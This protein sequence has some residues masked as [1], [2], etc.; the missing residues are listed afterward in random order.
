MWDSIYMAE[1]DNL[2]G[3]N[4]NFDTIKTLLNSIRAQG[5]LN[6]SDVDKLLTGIN[7]KLEKINTEE[8]IDLIKI[9][10][11]ELKQNLDERHSILV[12]KFGAIE[13]L[14]S[15]LLKNSSE[16]LKSSEVKELF[17]IVATNLSVFSREVVSQKESL[18][19]I[20]LR[21][22]AL[23]SDDSQKK[24]IIK[25][26]ALLK[27]DLE[28]LNNG[29]DSIVLSLNDNFKTIVKTISTIDKTEYLDKFSDS[30]SNIEMSSK[31]VLSALQVLDKKT[32]KVDSVL[33]NL[34]RK[35]DLSETN[36][37]IFE[38]TAQSH[39]LSASVTDLAD[40]YVRFDN[41]AD[42]I[43]ASVGI[44]AGLKSFL[45]EADD[46]STNTLL[47]ELRGIEHSIDK[48]SSDTKFEDFK[49]DLQ[50]I[51]NKIFE[52]TDILNKKFIDSQADIKSL[53]NKMSTIDIKTE[54]QIIAEK[55]ETT[56]IAIKDNISES[57]QKVLNLSE[58]NISRVLNEI[59]SSA[60]SL[61]S[62]LT[63]TQSSLAV[64]CEKNFGSVYENI[65]DLKTVLAQIDENSI[66]ANNAI[67]SSITDRLTSFENELSQSLEAQERTVNHSAAQLIEQVENIK[68]LSGVLDYKIDSSVVE[69]NSVKSGLDNLKS[70][71]DDVLALNFVN[72][73]KDLRIDLYASKQEL[74]NS[75]ETTS[76]DMADKLTEDL[77]GKY[78]LLISKLDSVE[79]EIKH[80]QNESLYSLKNVLENISSSIVD[81]LSYVSENNKQDLSSF[82]SKIA[83]ISSSIKETNL[84]YVESV[85][86]IV[87]VIRIQV[88]NNLKNIEAD[89]VGNFED[90]KKSISENTDELKQEIK[91]SYAKLLE[92][93]DSYNEI[94]DILNLYDASS[95]TKFDSI[96][97]TTNSIKTEFDAK[98]N[99]LK[100]NLLDKVTEF[101]QEYT[102]DN[103]DR[104]SDIKFAVENM[105][106][107]TT[108]DITDA[109]DK[110]KE[111]LKSL[112]ETVDSDMTRQMSIIESNFESLISQMNIV[113]EK[114]EMTLTEKINSEFS[115]LSNDVMTSV[116]EKLNLYKEK[117]DT[118]FEELSTKA[119][120]Q[121]EYLQ[122]RIV[123]L[124]STM[125]SVWEEQS[126]ENIKQIEEMANQFRAV[127]DENIKLT[128][129]DY[130]ALKNKLNDFAKNIESNNEKLSELLS[131]NIEN[132][133]QKLESIIGSEFAKVTGNQEKF[134]ASNEQNFNIIKDS[135]S[136]TQININ[137]KLGALKSAFYEASTNDMASISSHVNA[138]LEQI[139]ASRN[140]VIA[141]KEVLADLFAK[142]VKLLTENIEKETDA[143]IA[144]LVEQ[145]DL[146]KKSQADDIINLTTKIEDIVSG[147]IFNNIEDLKSYLDV[148]TD[149]T[150]FINRIDN[151]KIE[152]ANGISDLLER[153]NKLL[154][155]GVFTSSIKDFKLANEVLINSSIDRLNDKIEQFI[156]DNST[157][158]AG[159]IE[160]KSIN[161]EDKLSL[162]DK[163]FVETLVEKYE[164]I[165]LISNNC[166]K[167]LSDIQNEINNIFTKFESTKSDI[168]SRID[169]LI[170][171]INTANESTSNDVKE[172]LIAFNDLKSHLS[173]KSFDEAFQTSI[174]NQITGLE[175]LISEQ[176]G[177]I[178]DINDLCVANLPDISDLKGLIKDSVL[179]LVDDFSKKIDDQDIEGLLDEALKKF[180]SDIITQ[181]LNVFNQISFVAE[182]EEI[183]DFIQEKHEDLITILSHIV[184][185]TEG[186]SI[187]ENKIDTLKD[188]IKSINEKIMAIM[189]SDGDIDYVY[190]L[191]DIE[192][193]IA[194]LRLALN[195]IKQ[196]DN[197]KDLAELVSSTN[198][199]YALVESVKSELPTKQ[200]FETIAENIE[201]ISSR[202]NKLILNSDESYKTL[203]E[204][205]QEF[206]LVIDDLDERTRNFSKDS[207]IDKIDLK[208]NSINNLIQKGEK[209]NQVFNQVFEYLAE[210][211]DNASVQINTISDRVNSLDDIEQIKNILTELKEGATDNSESLEL[212]NAL[213]VVFNKQ[214]KKITSLEKKL[215]KIIVETTINSQNN[216]INL[217][218]MEDTLNKFLVA[219]DDKMSAQQDK[220]ASLETKLENVFKILD[221]KDTVQ[222]TKKVGGM[223]RQIAK[224]NKSIEKI[225]SH[226]VEK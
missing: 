191:Q 74:V 60:D 121:S 7:T 137:E 132:L 57:T 152:V 224:L 195:E 24:D 33:E 119:I 211:V 100:T 20:S 99:I 4:E 185:T 215:D 149:N 8:D 50:T 92:I 93:I 161:I 140:N 169:L 71:V 40:K 94:K 87:D 202:T 26:I 82:D 127:I 67:F 171:I 43:D 62:R 210:W 76:S 135:L 107:K 10:L 200:D 203:Q 128:A 28:R 139:D 193:D 160:Q 115:S 204:N 59:S 41:L 187:V 19:D 125:K 122:D 51:V 12:S 16:M 25:N 196:N 34:A 52:G 197:G 90:V 95:K 168:N 22:D 73:V 157:T 48:I 209:T 154:E 11:S 183:I 117:I 116:A 150:D 166:D 188:D 184:T 84:N 130:V 97:S 75:Y 18:T 218:P 31:T 83:E 199:V 155:T 37:K 190:S 120:S 23:R 174:N 159:V 213:E 5:I 81:V 21:L 162:F 114:T 181:F 98:L 178:E 126:E 141:C 68:N 173:S 80:A 36:R 206:K 53:L 46:K 96:I 134:N 39:E 225:A 88:E 103:A 2:A 113:S 49:N 129:V 217:E 177:Y 124:N 27:P 70:A 147:Q 47:E 221:E 89:S 156:S 6:T 133:N 226:V 105:Y 77:Y 55:F 1:M 65:T 192:A 158:I 56:A 35:E 29:F 198:Q 170:D 131:E 186:I 220:I 108:Q 72:V 212:V 30:L 138:I 142:D 15:N 180:K 3:I 111:I 223:D 102:C 63:E 44:I 112:D 78:E 148:K 214:A 17:D 143:I 207:G 205:L 86:D 64:L 61:S 69:L 79:E 106:S 153:Q 58:A 146:I 110:Q 54:Y 144:E 172:I 167:S 38:L 145:F 85:R 104:M 9:F 45:E 14:F 101:K 164:D 13:S 91:Y 208:L 165:K 194:N 222:L 109:L 179:T 189:T 66:S 201:S 32:E 151:L 42:K 136:E 216:K 182:Q 163:N 123:D 118:S 176:L 219:I 175:T